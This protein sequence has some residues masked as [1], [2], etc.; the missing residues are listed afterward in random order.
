MYL[1][2]G[3]ALF[4][5]TGQSARAAIRGGSHV[6]AQPAA[7]PPKEIR[8][9]APAGVLTDLD[10]FQKAQAAVLSQA[11][12]PGCHS[13]LRLIWQEFSEYEIDVE[14]RVSP[15]RGVAGPAGLG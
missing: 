14:G 7:V 12:C 6:R 15:V 4:T 9:T 3:R 5:S 8:I 2:A 11:G 10:A 13:G 1:A